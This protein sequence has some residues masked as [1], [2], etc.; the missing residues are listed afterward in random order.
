[1]P[2]FQSMLAELNVHM[3]KDKIQALAARKD[4]FHPDKETDYTFL[5]GDN[6]RLVAAWQ[7]H[8]KGMPPA[9]RY[10]LRAIIHQALSTSPPTQVTFAWTPGYDFEMTVTQA[11]DTK[12]TKGGITVLVKSRYPADTHPL[13]ATNTRG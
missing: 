13:D 4:E 8:L 10:G 11:P 12:S 9:I 7:E 5:M 2:A 1:M 3:G 6:P